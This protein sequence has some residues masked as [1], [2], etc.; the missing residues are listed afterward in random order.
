MLKLERFPA[1]YQ[2]ILPRIFSKQSIPTLISI[3]MA[4]SSTT[5]N[6][7]SKS[8]RLVLIV[9]LVVIGIAT[10]AAAYYFLAVKHKDT[11]TAPV[12]V[13][14]PIFIALEPFTVN[15]QPNGR[16]RF[17]HVGMS[18]KVL[19]T[20]SQ[21]QVTRYLPE[22]R[23][24]ILA[25]L[26]NRQSDSLLTAN[27]KTLLAGEITTALNQPFGSNLAGTLVSSVLFTTFVLQ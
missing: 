16:V 13:V 15:L 14:E 4:T 3:V 6:S 7:P 10:A 27:D 24:R 1:L 2:P 8:K 17:L 26:S 23:S 21:S 11:A 12:V 9:A 25:V 5:E 22:V 19:D 18:L 20:K